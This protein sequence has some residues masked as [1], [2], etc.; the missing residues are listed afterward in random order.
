MKKRILTTLIISISVTI[1]AQVVDDSITMQTG[2]THESYYSMNSGEILNVNNTD[3]DIAFELDGFGASIRSNGHTG[4][5]VWVYPTDT[6]WANV[7]T[8]GMI[9]DDVQYNSETTWS[10]GAFDQGADPQNPLDLGWGEYDM[11]T[12][13]ISG[14]RIFIVQLSTGDYKKLFINTLAN[15]A[16]NFRYADLNGANEITQS[17]TKSTYAGKNFIYYSLVTDQIIDREPLNDTW[18]LV[19]TRY[20]GY[21]NPPGTYY[22]VTGV[23]SNNGVHIREADGVAPSLADYNSFTVDSVIDVIGHDWKSFN[24]G[25]MQYEI[26]PDLSYFVEDLSGDL[27]HIIFTRFDLSSSGKVVFSKEKVASVNVE[28][29]ED[30][31]AFGIYPNPAKDIATVIYDG[32]SGANLTIVDMHGSIVLTKQLSSGFHTH[33]LNLESFTKGAFFVKLSTEHGSSTQKL[34][35]R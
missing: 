25:T 15:G 27:W 24:G 10:I 1:S 16:Y 31:N 6:V 22:N 5:N 3:W 19:F 17:I 21:L 30:L 2:R 18:D 14:D 8:T 13:I 26:V 34:V 9:W 33:P 35:V 12:H 11:V 23:L 4:T 28:E 7:D 29:I 32:E 20:M